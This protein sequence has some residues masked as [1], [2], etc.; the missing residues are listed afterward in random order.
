MMAYNESHMMAYNESQIFKTILIST[1]L[2]DSNSKYS[3]ELYCS[4]VL[5]I[6]NLIGVKFLIRIFTWP[7]IVKSFWIAN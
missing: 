5:F 3:L 7:T 4:W 2:V 1:L 6:K